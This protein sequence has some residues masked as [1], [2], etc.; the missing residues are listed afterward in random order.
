MKGIIIE[1]ILHPFFHLVWA[2]VLL[3]DDFVFDSGL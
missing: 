1:H 3:S 2:I